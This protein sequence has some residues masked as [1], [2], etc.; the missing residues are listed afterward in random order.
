MQRIILKSLTSLLIIISLSN[1][2]LAQ[3][4]GFNRAKVLKI[5]SLSAAFNVATITSSGF[6]DSTN[7]ANVDLP[8][9]FYGTIAMEHLPLYAL[10]PVEGI[11]YSGVQAGLLGIH[12]A[13]QSSP[14]VTLT[15]F[16]VYLKSSF[17]STYR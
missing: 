1:V 16:N 7:V 17:Y 11:K 10:N 4:E 8:G 3:S 2:G 13:T 5:T 9:W 6:I 12:L 15:P 14:F